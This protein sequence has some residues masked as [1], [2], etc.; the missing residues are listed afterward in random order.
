MIDLQF[1]VQEKGFTVAH[2]KTD[3][4]KIPD[5][6]PDIIGFVMAFGRKYGYTFE[7][8]ATYDRMCLVNNAVYIAKYATAEKCETLY[9]YVPGDNKKKGGKWTATGT[10][11]AVPYVFKS[12][13]SKED[14][15][16]E[17]M[18]ETKQVTSSLYLDMNEELP[19]VVMLENERA[20][21]S[22]EI[23][24]A[25]SKLNTMTEGRE[26]AEAKIRDRIK[27]L[28][29]MIAKGH[30]YHFVGRVGSFCPVKAGRGG[31]VLVRESGTDPV[32]D[33]L[34]TYA[35]ATGADG[36]RWME[37]EM[38]QTL[39]KEMDIDRS[40]YDNLV[41]NAVNAISELGDFEWF[42][43]DCDYMGVQYD[44]KGAPIYD[45]ELPF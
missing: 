36:Y 22:K 9:G 12:L 34:H 30:D 31:G 35:S 7:H 11:F 16:F 19:D 14:I 15:L 28:D 18:C 43:S 42:V 10:Q 8:E 21:L 40:Y 26:A 27:E 33:V 2:I 13:F 25:K 24:N 4:I 23:R 6:T 37:A 44:E 32:N 45:C 20:K 17:D 3:S 1:A 41:I 39:N 5:A 38:I 29:T